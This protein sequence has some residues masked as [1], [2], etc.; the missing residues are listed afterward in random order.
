MRCLGADDPP[1]KRCRA[2]GLDCV[3]E[4]PKRQSDA[5]SVPVADQLENRVA[6][7]ESTLQ[8]VLSRL[9]LPPLDA[10]G[11]STSPA[12]RHEFLPPSYSH[13]KYTYDDSPPNGG[14]SPEAEVHQTAPLHTL[15]DLA[16]AA[17]RI[18]S[19]IGVETKPI[20]IEQNL[21]Q[22]GMITEQQ[23]FELFDIFRNRCS[24]YMVSLDLTLLS[25]ESLSSM[26]P[27]LLAAIC[28]V[29]ARYQPDAS[30]YNRCLEEAKRLATMTLFS[31]DQE[32]YSVPA[33]AMLSGWPNMQ[34]RSDTDAIWVIIGHAARLACSM[35]LHRIVP[36]LDERKHTSEDEDLDHLQRFRSWAS[37]CVWEQHISIG[38]GK[39]P[40]YR[41]PALVSKVK[42]LLR[43]P[44]SSLNDWRLLAQC[45]FMEILARIADD[46]DMGGSKTHYHRKNRVAG[47]AKAIRGFNEE[48]TDWL[49]RWII[50]DDGSHSAY[51][52][53]QQ[54]SGSNTTPTLGF[55]LLSYYYARLCLNSY[56]LPHLSCEK[57][58]GGSS[59]GGTPH[60]ASPSTPRH[61]TV[62]ESAYD[63]T[64]TRAVALEFYTEAIQSACGLLEEAL[65]NHETKSFLPYAMD[66]V[67]CIIGFG[68]V[69]LLKIRKSVQRL[70]ESGKLGETTQETTTHTSR[71]INVAHTD[72]LVT[73]V[74]DLLKTSA[75]S[76]HHLSWRFGKLIS[77]M[78]DS[79]KAFEGKKDN[80]RLLDG[81]TQHWQQPTPPPPPQPSSSSMNLLGMMNAPVANPMQY[82]SYTTQPPI[83]TPAPLSI[84]VNDALLADN[85]LWDIFD[86]EGI[87]PVLSRLEDTMPQPF[88]Q[89]QP[90]PMPLQNSYM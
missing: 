81:V 4:K 8:M 18:A 40:I 67:F 22:S 63:D 1:C 52:K 25:K 85:N 48:L 60:S 73:G 53:P 82:V 29:A 24:L 77:G 88:Q 68:A 45:E 51:L 9:H 74:A 84:N 15:N 75:P 2:S 71:L 50:H 37:L 14:Q 57:R 3:F 6:R 19:Q 43:H 42:R 65:Q 23:A 80:M 56:I 17:S 39:S 31:A 12:A 59:S 28:S 41:D 16:D 34:W 30:L 47:M 86:S 69:F 11:G 61:P 70:A 62:E 83:Q 64:E 21:I 10:R 78:M 33:L 87:W 90:Q 27:L 49:K 32:F 26:H 89:Q 79:L 58:A 38:V 55:C 72:Q 36:R 44:R 54:N 76:E 35:G 46:L 5:P 7:V 13:P 66:F 20:G